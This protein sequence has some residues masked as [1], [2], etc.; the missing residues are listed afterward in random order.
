MLLLSV[1]KNCKFYVIRTVKKIVSEI[2]R[3]GYMT[4]NAHFQTFLVRYTHFGIVT[5]LNFPN[6]KQIHVHRIWKM[7]VLFFSTPQIWVVKQIFS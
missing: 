4:N 2:D 6:Q 3:F 5:G 1:N 7:H